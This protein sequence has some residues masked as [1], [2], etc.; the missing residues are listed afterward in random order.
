MK[1][2]SRGK[3]SDRALREE[4]DKALRYRTAPLACR[5]ATLPGNCTV[6]SAPRSR[7]LLPTGGAQAGLRAH[8]MH[9]SCT[10]TCTCLTPAPVCCLT[11]TLTLTQ[12]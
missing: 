9:M 12:P 11:L 1:R 4:T 5:A 10:C 7:R 8:D 6:A 2:S 3:K